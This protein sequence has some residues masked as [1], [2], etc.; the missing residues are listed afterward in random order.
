MKTFIPTT[1]VSL[2]DSV[3]NMYRSFFLCFWFCSDSTLAWASGNSLQIHTQVAKSKLHSSL[4][5]IFRIQQPHPT[6]QIGFGVFSFYLFRWADVLNK[7]LWQLQGRY[8]TW[9]IITTRPSLD[10]WV[11]VNHGRLH[12][13]RHHIY[14]FIGFSL[15][16]PTFIA[17]LQI[18]L[19]NMATESYNVGM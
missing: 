13:F 15:T 4:K 3:H 6:N 10:M 19:S 18:P 9:T 11:H 5:G 1:S 16:Q 12:A 2:S 7:Q 17:Y 8:I 14:L